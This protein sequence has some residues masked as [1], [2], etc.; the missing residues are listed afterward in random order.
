MEEVSGHSLVGAGGGSDNNKHAS[1]IGQ[2]EV[3]SL[4]FYSSLS[5]LIGLVVGSGIFSSP[6]PVYEEIG[7][8]Y[9]A[10][11]AW[12]V[13]GILSLLGALSYGELG[14]MYPSAGGEHV[15]LYKAFGS[16]FSFLFSFTGW[17]TRPTSVSVISLALCELILSLVYGKEYADTLTWATVGLSILIS[18]LTSASFIVFKE[19]SKWVQ[20]SLCVLKLGLLLVICLTG[21]YYLVKNNFQ[22]ADAI[23]GQTSTN[24][25]AIANGKVGKVAKS[26]Y[27]ALWGYDGWSNLNLVAEKMKNPSRNVPLV[28]GVGIS[29]IASLYVLTNVSYFAV[30][31]SS[32]LTGINAVSTFGELAYGSVGRIVILILV[33]MSAYGALSSTIYCNT[34]VPLVAA[35]DKYAPSFFCKLHPRFGTPANALIAQAL[36]SV[37]IS[38]IFRKDY[39]SLVTFYSLPFWVFYAGASAALI[40][41]RKKDPDAR[42]PFK[43]N[44][45][46]PILFVISTVF[47]IVFSFFETP[48]E[49]IA[50]IGLFAAGIACWYIFVHRSM[51]FTISHDS[52]IPRLE[53]VEGLYTKRK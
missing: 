30:L 36:I 44:I 42:R 53:T 39:G 35:A 23:T 25:D 32:D 52:K 43:V 24:E 4:G 7:T 20:N 17:V 11:S 34:E 14:A 28:L 48:Y 21:V 5:L 22:L 27:L 46:A 33:C 16:L 2:W 13:G 9:G 38:L 6:G 3:P 49:C 15:Y 29:I 45:I 40:C 51:R 50:A 37:V 47:M 10:V 8:F 12:I 26:L 41:L 19:S 31:S 1:Q 18:T